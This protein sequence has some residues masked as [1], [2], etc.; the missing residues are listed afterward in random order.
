MSE[1]FCDRGPTRTF[2]QKIAPKSCIGRGGG[3]GRGGLGGGRD[4]PPM[5]VR[6]S[7]GGGG[8][9]KFLLPAHSFFF[10][11]V[12]PRGGGGLRKKNLREN[13]FR[14]PKPEI[15]LTLPHLFG[16]GRCKEGIFQGNHGY[17]SRYGWYL[18]LRAQRPPICSGCSA[19]PHPSL[20]SAGSLQPCKQQSVD[21]ESLS[22]TQGATQQS[23]DCESLTPTQGAT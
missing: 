15:S 19:A 18:C 13:F 11:G 20:L 14:T 3:R 1:K 4:P 21:C 9:K 7:R 10:R 6:Q 2:L 5:V 8:R 23:V 17:F 22:P 12:F 16:F